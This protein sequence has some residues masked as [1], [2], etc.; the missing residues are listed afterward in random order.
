MSHRRSLYIFF[1]EVKIHRHT[2]EKKSNEEWK[3][4]GVCIYIFF[5][6]NK[7]AARHPHK[8]ASKR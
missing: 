4:E 5:K 3:S 2:K 6:I 8:Q 7:Y 1:N